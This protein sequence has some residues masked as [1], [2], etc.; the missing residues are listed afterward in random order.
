MADA[1]MIDFTRRDEGDPEEYMELT[2]REKLICM[3]IKLR[4]YED[5]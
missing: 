5:D 1:D 4:M 3:E 2:R